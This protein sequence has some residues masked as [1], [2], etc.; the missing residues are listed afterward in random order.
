[1]TTPPHRT[2]ADVLAGETI[3][4][5]IWTYLPDGDAPF[6]VEEVVQAVEGKLASIYTREEMAGWV[7]EG[8]EFTPWLRSHLKAT[9]RSRSAQ[10]GVKTRQA[11]R[12]TR[13]EDLVERKRAEH[14]E[15]AEA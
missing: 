5:L 12:R 3:L 7:L 8:Q 10:R 2:T 4:A 6:D 13:F 11:N 15:P 1:V 14:D 9:A